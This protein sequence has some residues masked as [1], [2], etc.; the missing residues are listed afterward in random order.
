[1]YF[2]INAEL[3][4][5]C[6]RGNRLS[7]RGYSF[8]REIE[9][10]MVKWAQQDIKSDFSSRSFRTSTSGAATASKGDVRLLHVPWLEGLCLECKH[11]DQWS[12]KEGACFHL[13]LSLLDKI[14][15]EAHECHSTPVL[16]WAF[17]NV[18]TNKGE[19]RVQF[20]VPSYA[21]RRWVAAA[22]HPPWECA[23]DKIPFKDRLKKYYLVSH[24]TLW[25][26]AS[27]PNVIT[28]FPITCSFN[29][30][31]VIISRRHLEKLLIAVRDRWKEK[32]DSNVAA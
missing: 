1:M 13:Y 14:S 18:H 26:H 20:V 6:G 3:F 29:V 11:L 5:V 28:V 22:G 23:M 32:G 16:T 2:V 7:R 15:K 25:K 30:Q 4:S 12:K 9:C 8:E 27:D 21:F 31:W 24:D 19:G 10:L 17:K